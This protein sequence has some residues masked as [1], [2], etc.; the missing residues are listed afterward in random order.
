[1]VPSPVPELKL[2]N[3]PG[4]PAVRNGLGAVTDPGAPGTCADVAKIQYD[5]QR[6]GSHDMHV[7]GAVM[8]KG[9]K[10]HLMNQFTD[11]DLYL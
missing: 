5:N 1:M 11:W 9:G 3:R 6:H 4:P 7:T 2:P 10:A 8:V